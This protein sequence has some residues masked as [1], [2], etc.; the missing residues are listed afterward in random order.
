M[1]QYDGRRDELRFGVLGDVMMRRESITLAVAM[2]L[3]CPPAARAQEPSLSPAE[4]N[5]RIQALVLQRNEALDRLAITMAA[6]AMARA[7]VERLRR[8][9]ETEKAG[10]DAKAEAKE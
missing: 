2:A 4:L 8:A 7:E 9:A 3:A 6:E 1:H 5:A 10:R